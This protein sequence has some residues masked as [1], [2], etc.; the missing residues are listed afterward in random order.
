M[1]DAFASNSG[2]YG[3]YHA[4][5]S[6]LAETNL[7][8]YDSSEGNSSNRA[9]WAENGSSRISLN[10][11]LLVDNETS[12]PIVVGETGGNGTITINGVSIDSPLTT[13]LVQLH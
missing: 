6:N 10:G 4:N 9:W 8:S 2:V 7:T 1:N 13:S 3:Y 11:I 12:N 5:T